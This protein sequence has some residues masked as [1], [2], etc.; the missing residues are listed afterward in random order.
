MD[1]IDEF[2]QHEAQDGE[3]QAPSSSV[4][5]S[6]ESDAVSEAGTVALGRRRVRFREPERN[7]GVERLS[8]A[9][10]MGVAYMIGNTRVVA[11]E[12]SSFLKKFAINLI[13]R[14]LRQN[15]QRP[16]VALGIP[17]TS[18]IEVGMVYYI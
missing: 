16:A 13:Y 17:H 7:V 14:F 9:K 10:Q 4:S 1:G 15:C 12:E 5:H 6:T 18:L 2:L 3:I 11:R 8:E